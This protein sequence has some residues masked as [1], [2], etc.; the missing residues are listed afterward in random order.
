[1]G[2]DGCQR[3]CRHGFWVSYGTILN[4]PVGDSNHW[5]KNH[6]K[7]WEQTNYEIGGIKSFS[8]VFCGKQVN[9]II[10]L[11]FKDGFDNAFLAK[12]R[13]VECWVYHDYTSNHQVIILSWLVVDLPLWKIWTSNGI[14][15]PNIWKNNHQP[16]SWWVICSDF[17]SPL[18][19]LF[20]PGKP[21][22][23]NRQPQRHQCWAVLLRLLTGEWW[24]MVEVGWN[25]S[26]EHKTS[27]T[28]TQHG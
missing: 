18:W 13:I 26:K 5:A 28:W 14:I 10:T 19:L 1:M 20:L 21:T 2:D 27:T 24:Q 8:K 15:I 25:L 23:T 3:F 4:N 7:I 12:F 9:P 6:M 16:V 17:D 22:A 11:Q